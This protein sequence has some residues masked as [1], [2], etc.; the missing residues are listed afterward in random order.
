MA[1]STIC[2]AFTRPM[3]FS[4]ISARR[5]IVVDTAA[6]VTGSAARFRPHAHADSPAIHARSHFA[7]TW[8]FESAW[9]NV[10][11]WYPSRSVLLRPI[12]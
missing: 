7:G 8:P 12:P 11:L 9:S 4:F 2:N 10:F 5:E 6:P 3:P 1:R